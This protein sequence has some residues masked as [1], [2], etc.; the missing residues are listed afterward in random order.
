VIKTCATDPWFVHDE[1]R[2]PGS[3]DLDPAL[4]ARPEQLESACPVLGPAG[5]PA[6]PLMP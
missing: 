2:K 5:L 1:G 4:P 3:V 6:L